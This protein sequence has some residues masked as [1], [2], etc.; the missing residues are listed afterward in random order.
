MA[1]YNYSVADAVLHVFAG[2][3]N[4]QR[5]ELLRVFEFLS[6]EPFA[7]GDSTQAD[8]TGRRCQVKRF[9]PWTVTYW[10]EHLVKEVHILDV[11]RL[12]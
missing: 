9:G 1:A 4:R 8:H 6:K 10:P 12:G 2:A 5:Q 3:T 7:E 11:E